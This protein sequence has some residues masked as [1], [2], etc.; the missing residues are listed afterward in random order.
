[1]RF[2]CRL[3]LKVNN[4]E[5]LIPSDYRKYISAM[6]K[7]AFKLSGEDGIN[8]L[9]TKI[10]E[11]KR[12]KPYTFSVYFP[13]KEYKDKFIILRENYFNFNFSSFDYEYL[14]R[15]YN[16]LLK[17]RNGY[18]VFNDQAEVESFNLFL[19]PDYTFNDEVVFKTLSPFLVP[20]K[21]NHYYYVI[22]GLLNGKKFKYAKEVENN[23][24]IKALKENIKNIL[25]MKNDISEKDILK[26]VDEMEINFIELNL[27]PALH[28]SNRS[29]FTV[30]LPAMKGKIKI[31]SK[32]E[33]L[34]FLY[35]AGIGARRSQGFGMLEVVK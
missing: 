34:K 25:K 30:T 24:L 1:M 4:N 6:I 35:D 8:F 18:K 13:V 21:E 28:G 14:L 9:Q 17:L 32:P 5:I 16:G 23:E 33:I 26:L 10:C 19:K 7:E 29:K 12:Q 15:I 20:D 27:S 31:K 2:N 11:N 22:K 3:R